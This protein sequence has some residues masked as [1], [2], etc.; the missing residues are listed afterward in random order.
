AP[1]DLLMRSLVLS[2]IQWLYFDS[3]MAGPGTPDS[4]RKVRIA[5]RR[6]RTDLQTFGALLEPEWTGALR[7]RI[8]ALTTRLGTVRD[9]EVLAGRL[10]EL[11][12]LLPEEERPAALPIVD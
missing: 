3:E 5:A 2:T 10:A 6:I 8:G 12:A 1:R 7:D 11:A 9:A 4:I